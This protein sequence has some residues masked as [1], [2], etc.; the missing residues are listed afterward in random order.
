MAELH[1]SLYPLYQGDVELELR[2]TFDAV[3]HLYKRIRPYRL[4]KLEEGDET[5]EQTLQALLMNLQTAEDHIN[6]AILQLQDAQA[7]AELRETR[8]K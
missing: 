1:P 3:G 5:E 7:I 4:R 6:M 2:R 8:P